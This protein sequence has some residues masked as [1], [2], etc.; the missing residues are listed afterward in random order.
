MGDVL[1]YNRGKQREG[2][3]GARLCYGAIHGEGS[4]VCYVIYGRPLGAIQPELAQDA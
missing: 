4:G 1:R 3:G 2:E